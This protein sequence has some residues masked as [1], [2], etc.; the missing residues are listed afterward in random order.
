MLWQAVVVW[1][2]NVNVRKHYVVKV[3]NVNALKVHVV[4]IASAYV[5]KMED[6]AKTANAKIRI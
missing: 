2:S 1:S 3:D 4:V 6:V 5:V